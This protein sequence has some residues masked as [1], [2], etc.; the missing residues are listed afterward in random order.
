[1]LLDTNALIE[2][3]AGI[4]ASAVDTIH[5]YDAA[6][7]VLA[8]VAS[9]NWSATATT[10]TELFH[11]AIPVGTTGVADHFDLCV[12]ANVF[13]TGSCGLSGADLNFNTLALVSGDTLTLT[14]L[15]ITFDNC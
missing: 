15:T 2:I 9:L 13:F 8:T 3:C 12:G 5:I 11:P 6:N 10:M 14:S 1:M 4:V 7:V